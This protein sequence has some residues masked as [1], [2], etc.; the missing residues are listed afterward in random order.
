MRLLLDTNTI[1]SG[2]FWNGVPEQVYQAA[3]VEPHILLTSNALLLELE[4][5]LRRPKF[6]PALTASKQTADSILTRHREIVEIASPADVPPVSVRDPK[7]RAVLACAV[8]RR[9]DVI[10]SGDKDLL[11]LGSFEGIPILT[12]QQ[13]LTLFTN[14]GS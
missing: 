1:I 10:V 7:G 12:A 8:G 13:C 3:S 9:A 14:P 6:A 5:I 2:L 4:P 11:V